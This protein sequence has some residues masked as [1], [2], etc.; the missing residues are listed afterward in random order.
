[1]EHPFAKCLLEAMPALAPRIE[2]PRLIEELEHTEG[3]RLLP[4]NKYQ[5]I[6]VGSKWNNLYRHIIEAKN[7]ADKSLIDDFFAGFFDM[8]NIKYETRGM[9]NMPCYAGD[10][11]KFNVGN[12]VEIICFIQDRPD[13]SDENI[14][15]YEE[16][17]R[18]L[19]E[20]TL[21]RI[22]LFFYFR[23][24]NKVRELFNK[25][26]LNL[27]PFHENDLKT[28]IC[29]DRPANMLRK[30]ILSRLSLHKITPYH[31]SGP[32]QTVFFGRRKIIERILRAPKISYS[33]V[34]SRKVGKTSLL[35]KIKEDFPP[36]LIN[37]HMS[38][39]LIFRK[40]SGNKIDV[41]LNALE[42]ELS[43]VLEKDIHIDGVSVD[44]KLVGLPN[45]VKDNIPEGKRLVFIFDEIDE[46]I[47]FDFEYD[48]PLLR[49]FRIM[50]Q[51]N[52]CQFIFAGFSHLFHHKRDIDSP[53]Y[54]FC[55]EILLKP[56]DKKSA[57]ALVTEPMRSIGIQY[58]N[59]K[60]KDLMLDYSGC[61]PNLLQ[62]YC[63]KVI[64]ILEEKN[65]IDERRI[66]FRD[67]VETVFSQYYGDYLMDDVY[68]FKSDQDQIMRMVQ[69]LM[70]Y[71]I[72][73]VST[74]RYNFSITD[75]E[76]RKK[77]KDYKISVSNETLHQALQDLKIRFVLKE[78]GNNTFTFAL[79]DFPEILKE[80]I[81]RIYMDEI[82]D[83]LKNIPLFS[84]FLQ[85]LL[86]GLK[87]LSR[88]VFLKNLNKK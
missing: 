85:I 52:I 25:P 29:S 75:E 58:Q 45:I 11:L 65:D 17:S 21:T 28:V 7:I 86:K 14:D 81:D 26:H 33:I 55:E 56:L 18:E 35:Y 4:Y 71:R 70:V 22:S 44:D 68:M 46:L 5:I 62:F 51:K 30:I 6:E 9:L 2:F 47:V 69:L 53:L 23:K 15:I 12:L 82:V 39:E 88:L 72:Q 13:L 79:P 34:G 74:L 43:A 76:L 78:S 59:E 61:H 57:I 48:Y 16:Y 27:I 54:N 84:R 10:F 77:F 31:T 3:K 73:P 41:F 63:Q 19:A 42:N 20:K 37:V 66:I 83:S 24:S 67:D 38:L 40:Q 49:S 60:V 8:L 64:E 87:K 50:A 80:R 32:A 36:D 1:L